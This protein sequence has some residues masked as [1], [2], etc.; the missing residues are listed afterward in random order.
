MKLKEGMKIKIKTWDEMAKIGEV[1]NLD[2]LYS[3]ICIK[4]KGTETYFGID[5]KNLCGK[6]IFIS[7][8]QADNF[9]SYGYFT[10]SGGN[11]TRWTIIKEMFE[12]LTNKDI[13]EYL[14]PFTIIEYNDGTK[15]MIVNIIEKEII[16]VNST[17]IISKVHD[18]NKINRVYSIKDYTNFS[19]SQIPFDSYVTD[20]NI[21]LVW[22][23]DIIT[24]FSDLPYNEEFIVI[25][26]GNEFKGTKVKF[27]DKNFLL[28]TWKDDK[29]KVL[30]VS[31]SEDE[32][33][34]YKKD[35]FEFKLNR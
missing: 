30:S 27:N 16:A 29:G 25:K 19:L 22:E 32:I 4:F 33:E 17:G 1:V 5:M 28:Y 20:K 23:K 7:S 35:S 26:S 34:N 12:E 2:K 24:K 13:N 18:I 8:R 14:K 3:K 11:G 31:Y 10:I 15:K 6:I 9:N 21:E